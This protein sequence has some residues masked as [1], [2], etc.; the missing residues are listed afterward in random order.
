MGGHRQVTMDARWNGELIASS[1][2]I[3]KLEGN[4]YFPADSLLTTHLRP[5]SH[6]TV[7]SWKGAA[8]Y[9]D[10]VVNGAANRDACWYYPACKPDA[11]HIEG[12]VAFWR[13]V[14]VTA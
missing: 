12:Y 8:S 4:A 7:C 13:G 5:S 3:V 1:D 6:T 10:V 14:E 11:K 9:Y 2:D